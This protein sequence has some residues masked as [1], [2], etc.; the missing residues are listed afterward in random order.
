MQAIGELELPKANVIGIIPSSE[1]LLSGAA[2]KPG[3][4]VIQ[5]HLGKTIEIDEHGR[6]GPADPLR[7]HSRTCAASSRWPLSDAAT[8]TGA[9]R[10]RASAT[11]TSAVMGN[12]EALHRGAARSRGAARE[13]RVWPLPMD[14]V[15]REQLKS[16]YADIKNVGGP[17]RPVR[18]RRAGSCAISSEDFPWAH[19]DVAG[20]AYGDGKLS[21]QVK[22]STSGIPTRLFVEWVRGRAA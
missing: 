17:G 3:D 22:G 2:L 7:T 1:N 21:Y 10:D 19:L 20:T 15:Y 16:D 11:R 6:R 18:S 12:D 8:L 5:S 9:C 13:S 4:I 14:D